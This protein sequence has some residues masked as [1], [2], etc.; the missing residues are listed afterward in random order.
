MAQPWSAV[1]SSPA[2][3]AL[4]LEE[5]R[6]AATQYFTTQ[7]APQIP[8]QDRA[9]AMSQFMGQAMPGAPS[10]P[11]TA[12]P[13]Q[14]KSAVPSPQEQGPGAIQRFGEGVAST[15]PFLN[16]LRRGG[17]DKGAQGAGEVAGDVGLTAGDLAAA[18]GT[19]A[20]A[21]ALKFAGLS[22]AMNAA[23]IP[24]AA[25]RVGNRAENATDRL[26]GAN[27]HPSK[28]LGVE[29]LG[30]ALNTAEQVPGALASTAIQAIPY[31]LAGKGA[32][33]GEPP[34]GGPPAQTPVPVREPS[35]QDLLVQHG[36]ELTPAMKAR[37]P[38]LGNMVAAFER[39][40][41]NNPFV[42]GPFVQ[43]L[44]GRNAGAVQNYLTSQ[45]GPEVL[46]ERPE[47]Y[48]ARLNSTLGAF[49]AQRS[50]DI[51]NAEAA[52]GR[53]KSKLPVSP[54]KLAANQINQLLQAG[55]VPVDETGFRPDLMTGGEKIGRQEAEMLR[56][57]AQ[58]AR[59]MQTIPE[60]LNLR[61]NLDQSGIFDFSSVP[62]RGQAL[63][64]KGR[65][66]LNNA[67]SQAID[68]SGNRSVIDQWKSANAKYAD[69]ADLM[70]KVKGAQLN[71][72]RDQDVFGKILSNPA[73]GG[74]SLDRLKAN[75]PP[76][77][78][79]QTQ[80]GVINRILADAK[81]EGPQGLEGLSA[82]KLKSGV[83]SRYAPVIA[84]LD[85]KYQTALKNAVGMTELMERVNPRRLNGSGSGIM[86]SENGHLGLGLLALN[87][88]W[89]REVL[90]LEL[91]AQ[92]GY[93]GLNKAANVLG[94][95]LQELGQ[96]ARA[97]IPGTPEIP[98]A[99]QTLGQAARVPDVILR[100]LGRKLSA[101]AA[102]KARPG[103]PGM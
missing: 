21:P 99:P 49:N 2:F 63:L 27:Q 7:I 13:A 91:G 77:L 100:A 65:G 97:P 80:K 93:Y 29:G 85:P 59:G 19:G 48:G 3:K 35:I 88:P 96:A 98:G 40:A 14:E 22:G 83:F 84:S 89:A 6:A 56:G 71:D 16:T 86:N 92:T 5:Q 4:P 61:R 41:R 45:F 50:S 82:A 90:G 79:D 103:A 95:Q 30:T 57:L 70:N 68:S 10:I 81:V 72:L 32:T 23:G 44:M 62:D 69:T 46:F 24:Q 34:A 52:L 102:A 9:G 51:A 33:V 53:I 47:D 12:A 11:S 94:P 78:W 55:G 42:V 58:K 25:E 87:S 76:D 26:L 20:I 38:I 64:N 75:M 15:V 60:L 43:K 18:L 17:Y 1:S 37:N 28:V 101:A 74:P 66:I 73:T 54:G 67:L 8:E 36:G 39:G 31:Y